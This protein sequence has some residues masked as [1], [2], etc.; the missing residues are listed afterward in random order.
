MKKKK[1]ILGS[2]VHRT[3]KQQ[4]REALKKLHGYNGQ[5]TA[6]T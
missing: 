5:R 1:T 4:R 6:A 3:Y 2:C